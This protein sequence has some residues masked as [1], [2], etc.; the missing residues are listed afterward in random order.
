MG[1]PSR[2]RQQGESSALQSIFPSLLPSP[3]TRSL[4][5]SRL[6]HNTKKKTGPVMVPVFSWLGISD[7]NTRMTES[8]SVALPLGESP[9]NGL[10]RAFTLHL[11]YFSKLFPVWQAF[12]R[13][14]SIFFEK[15]WK[16][17]LTTPLFC[18]II[19]LSIYEDMNICEYKHMNKY[20][21]KEKAGKSKGKRRAFQ[22]KACKKVV[23]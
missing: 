14:F 7:S 3:P 16:I 6:S 15:R 21:Y 10:W 22:G 12:S 20:S 1:K 11:H 23:G 17:S 19:I 2:R 13:L 5:F 18:S 9:R 4:V 8:E